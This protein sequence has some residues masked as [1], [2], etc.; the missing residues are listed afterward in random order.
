VGS[1]S[2]GT[3]TSTDPSGNGGP[4]TIDAGTAKGGLFGVKIT[5]N[6]SFDGQVLFYDNLGVFVGKVDLKTK[7]EELRQRGLVGPDGKYTLVAT[8]H[9]NDDKTRHLA[10]GV[11]MARLISF[12]VQ[13]VNGVQQRVM[14]Q[15]KLFK[16]GYKKNLK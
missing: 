2:S 5:L 6:T 14:I 9:D 7:I 12:S 8:L 4:A 11:F 10:S 15:N 13:T 1:D 3:W 16:V